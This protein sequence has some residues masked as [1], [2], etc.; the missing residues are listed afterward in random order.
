MHKE[1][2]RLNVGNIVLLS[3][4]NLTSEKQYCFSLVIFAIL[5]KACF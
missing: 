3:Y 2:T 5:F 4:D 1:D